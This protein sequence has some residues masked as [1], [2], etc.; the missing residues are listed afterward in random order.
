MTVNAD[1][2]VGEHIPRMVATDEKQAEAVAGTDRCASA[3]KVARGRA[4]MGT[5]GAGEFGSRAC[6]GGD[7][8]P[9]SERLPACYAPVV[10]QRTVCHARGWPRSAP[11]SVCFPRPKGRLQRGACSLYG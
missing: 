7:G 10:I 11:G 9:S 1:F 2:T 4:N 3:P 6:G 8:K 5:R